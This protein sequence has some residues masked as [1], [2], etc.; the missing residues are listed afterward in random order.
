MH[1]AKRVRPFLATGLLVALCLAAA[2]LILPA[3]PALT[4][5]DAAEGA[6]L[7]AASNEVVAV[8]RDSRTG[9]MLPFRKTDILACRAFHDVVSDLALP[10]GSE[11]ETI[12]CDLIH[13]KQCRCEGFESC[14][15]L[16]D[17]SGLCKDGAQGVVCNPVDPPECG[18]D[19]L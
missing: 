19:T 11:V 8:V 6:R 16:A 12:V 5:D 13:L 4:Q 17:N 15:W 10:P 3:T 1:H 2:Y 9:R 14:D 18:C 7:F